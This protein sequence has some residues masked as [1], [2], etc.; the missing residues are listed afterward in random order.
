MFTTFNFRRRAG[1][2]SALVAPGAAA[3]LL[4]IAACQDEL[5]SARRQPAAA[6]EAQKGGNAIGR[7]GNGTAVW[8]VRDGNL[9]HLVG[10][11]QFVLTGRNNVSLLVTDNLTPADQDAAAGSFKMMGLVPGQ[12]Q[13]ARSWHRG[14]PAAAQR[15]HVGQH[16]VEQHDDCRTLLQ[17]PHGARKLERGRSGR[18]SAWQRVLHAL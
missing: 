11:A 16:L 17:L 9:S 2:A 10:G 3:I 6:A 5:P 4:A 7:Q 1:I 15:V 8:T 12:Y 18:Q 14:L 13:F